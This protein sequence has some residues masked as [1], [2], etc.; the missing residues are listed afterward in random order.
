MTIDFSISE[1][2]TELTARFSI[3]YR[4]LLI[5]INTYIS[6]N[7]PASCL[8]PSVLKLSCA[9]ASSVRVANFAEVFDKEGC[10]ADGKTKQ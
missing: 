3:A 1:V 7:C 8:H 4:R 2:W 6:T 5:D 10:I 9:S